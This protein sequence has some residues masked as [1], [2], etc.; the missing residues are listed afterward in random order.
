MGASKRKD[1][2][3]ESCGD[4]KHT[5]RYQNTEWNVMIAVQHD[6]PDHHR[7]A[8][9]DLERLAH[10]VAE[11]QARRPHKGHGVRTPLPNEMR[12]SCGAT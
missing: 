1:S 11:P 3:H 8:A 9:G 5:R 12:V 10:S 4:E 7:R 6:E 2:I